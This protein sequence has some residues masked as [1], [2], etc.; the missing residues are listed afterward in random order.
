MTLTTRNV[1]ASVSIAVSFDQFFQQAASD[2]VRGGAEGHLTRL[3]VDMPLLS[4]LLEHPLHQPIYLLRCLP[5]TASAIFLKRLQFLFILDLDCRAQSTDVFIHLDQ[6]SAQPEKD[7]VISHLRRAFSNSGPRRRFCAR[8]WPPQVVFH[9]YWGPCP[10]MCGP[11]QAHAPYLLRKC[12][13][14]LLTM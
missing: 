4:D 13:C 2:P 10:G 9:R 5:E 11:A 7:L 6:F 14:R 8:L 12:A 3:Y 1:G